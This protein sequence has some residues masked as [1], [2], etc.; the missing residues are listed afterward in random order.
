MRMDNWIIKIQRYYQEANRAANWLA[1]QGAS[2]TNGIV[3]PNS[4][5]L[6]PELCQILFKDLS[7]AA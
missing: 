2:L 1:N 6:S 3:Y 4:S 5:L 7:S